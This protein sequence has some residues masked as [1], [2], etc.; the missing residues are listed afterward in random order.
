MADEI[1][2]LPYNPQGNLATARRSE[3]PITVRPSTGEGFNFYVPKYAPYFR[4]GFKLY[5]PDT[6]AYLV[7][8]VDYLHTH[9]FNAMS[10]LVG[11]EI[12]GSIMFIDREFS[13]NLQCSY[14]SLGGE[15]T[16]DARQMLEMLAN[17]LV[18]P[19]LTYWERVADTPV[20]FPPISHQHNIATDTMTWDD[21][22]A[23]LESLKSP[24]AQGLTMAMQALAQHE[25]R[26]DNPHATTKAQV[27][28]GL[29]QNFRLATTADLAGAGENLYM[30]LAMTRTM[31][32]NLGGDSAASHIVNYNNPHQ[33]NKTQV[34]LGNIENYLIATTGEMT[35]G[36]QTN[37]YTTPAGVMAAI[38]SVTDPLTTRVGVLESATAAHY[39]NTANPHSTTKA[40]VGLGNVDNFLTATTAEAAAGSVT[41]KFMTPALVK[42]AITAL[43][44]VSVNAHL[45]DL[46][47]PHQTT[48]AQVGLSQV[49]NYPV[50]SR[51]DAIGG[52]VTDKYMTPALVKAAIETFATGGLDNHL[53]DYDNPHETN[54]AQVGLGNVDNFASAVEADF[55]ASGENLFMTLDAT[56]KLIAGLGGDSAMA[57]IANLNNPHQTTKAQ[58]GLGNVQNYAIATDAQAVEITNATTYMTPKAVWIAVRDLGTPKN[59]THTAKDVGALPIVGGTMLGDIVVSTM[60]DG[61]QTGLMINGGANSIR[62]GVLNLQQNLQ[63]PKDLLSQ[64]YSGTID[65][66]DMTRNWLDLKGDVVGVQ[67]ANPRSVA[68]VEDPEYPWNLDDNDVVIKPRTVGKLSDYLKTTFIDLLLADARFAAKVSTILQDYNGIIKATDFEID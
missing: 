32:A 59:H 30:T 52:V 47:N 25:A 63:S 46:N 8:G 7:E 61:T 50:A 27:G 56:R 65:I 40:Q 1:V 48:K 36:T 15:F 34:G 3:E 64:T 23:A 58:V 54:K 53:S 5:N 9:A 6:N 68:P 67:W 62:V 60:S 33:V 37:R 2:R 29:V 66:L 19:R 26:K 28:L 43:A 42:A 49:L 24:L 11:L 35:I 12:Y 38:K 39:A 55:Q 18:D 45:A 4:N 14:Y 51:N 13:G 10:Q 57:H 16:L 31:I 41:D 17:N 21:V 22:V 20:V 44:S